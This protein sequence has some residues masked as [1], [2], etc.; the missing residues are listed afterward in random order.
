M[1]WGAVQGWLE[2]VKDIATS[3]T[4]DSPSDL[5]G[6]KTVYG[7]CQKYSDNFRITFGCF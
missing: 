5:E 6:H 4:S 3:R 2:T 7:K 1:K